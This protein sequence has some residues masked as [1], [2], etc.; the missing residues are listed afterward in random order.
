VR[1]R[2]QSEARMRCRVL[3]GGSED[4]TPEARVGAWALPARGCVRGALGRGDVGFAGRE[5]P[6]APRGKYTGWGG[7]RWGACLAANLAADLI[8][9]REDIVVGVLVVVVAVCGLW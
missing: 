1:G 6:S 8:A 7:W 5:V 9:L 3:L 2:G 4:F